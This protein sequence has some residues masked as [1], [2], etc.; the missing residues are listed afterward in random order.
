MKKYILILCI[1]FITTF[2][3]FFPALQKNQIPFVG[4]EMYW[5]QTARILPYIAQH[6]FNDPYWREFM[7]F[8]NFNGAKWVYAIGLHLFG[9]SDFSAVGIPP[10][11]VNI[12]G[13]FENKPFPVHHPLYPILYHARIISILATSAAITMMFIFGYVVLNRNYMAA[14]LSTVLLRIHPTIVYISSH[15]LAD[16]IFLAAEIFVLILL[17]RVLRLRNNKNYTINIFLGIALGYFVSVKINAA[18]FFCIILTDITV[19]HYL[20]QITLKTFFRTLVILTFTAEYAFL[21]LHPNLFFYR[22]Y[23]L[24]MMI[25]DRVNVTHYHMSYYAKI[26]PA[27]VLFT[28]PQ[29]IYSMAH[30]V[31][32]PITLLFFSLGLIGS[33]YILIKNKF[34]FDIYFVQLINTVIIIIFIMSYVVFDDERYF[35]PILPFICLIASSW[36]PTWKHNEK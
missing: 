7:G 9:H 34:R 6:K 12:W 33:I 2:S 28:I 4:D 29:R 25:A 3:S 10:Q 13:K 31:F 17:L 16:S 15:A 18:L 26:D 30:H 19:W 35:M 32:T 1:I 21:L 11:T 14:L 22:S 36:I 23:S 24:M 8:T 5:I 27:H 20:Q